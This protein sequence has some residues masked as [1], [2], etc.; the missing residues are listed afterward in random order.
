MSKL[1][2]TSA[3]GFRNWIGDRLT[4][5]LS[6]NSSPLT[7]PIDAD[8]EIVSGA[9]ME[10]I[11]KSLLYAEAEIDRRIS[12]AVDTPVTDE[13]GKVVLE[14]YAYSLAAIALFSRSKIDKEEYFKMKDVE[15]KLDDISLGNTSLIPRKKPVLAHGAE[16]AKVFVRDIQ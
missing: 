11:M 14:I 15:R 1:H 10:R 5:E 4:E 8:E 7:Q 16:K 3:E 2:Y 9:D 13:R 6:L 12:S